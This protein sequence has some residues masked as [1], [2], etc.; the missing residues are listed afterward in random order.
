MNFNWL[1]ASKYRALLTSEGV[2]NSELIRV[3]AYTARDLGLV[4]SGFRGVHFDQEIA[5]ATGRELIKGNI[6]RVFWKVN[7][8]YEWTDSE[9]KS[10][11][12]RIVRW[13]SGEF[14]WRS[15]KPDG[16]FRQ[17]TWRSVFFDRNSAH[18]VADIL[19]PEGGSHDHASR[20]PL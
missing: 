19:S 4:A 3:V 2:G 16:S 5:E 1:S 18:R 14:N 17:E 9:T 8:A 7:P 11:I 13:D 20:S 10:M 15:S 6:W 12:Q